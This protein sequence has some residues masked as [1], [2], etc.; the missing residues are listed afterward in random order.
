[1]ASIDSFEFLF[2]EVSHLFSCYR[3]GLA[4]IGTY[5]TLKKA[6]QISNYVVNGL[7]NNV[8]I[9][10]HSKRDLRVQFGMWAVVTGGSDGIGRA[11]AQELASRGMNIVLISRG[12]KRLYDA[13]SQIKK[14]FNVQTCTVAVDFSHTEGTYDKIRKALGDKEIGVLVNNVGMMYDFPR[15]FLDVP[16]E[17][18]SQIIQVNCTAAT[19][20]THMVLPGMLKRKR[21]AVVMMSSG[22][23]T[24]C[25]PQMT[26]YAATK[27]YLDYFTKTLQYEYKGKGVIIQC[28]KPFYVATKMTEYSETLSNPNLWI[29]S[30]SIY[31]RHAVKTLGRVPV[32]TGYWP[33]AILAWLT[34]LI[35]E[36]LWMW[37]ASGLNTAL[38]SQAKRRSKHRKTT[39]SDQSMDSPSDHSSFLS[40]STSF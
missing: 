33:H 26:V 11:Y 21:G 18:L 6:Y 3:D 27:S 35:P 13:A 24:Q 15:Y 1:M 23:C 32:S 34:E 17:N 30:A 22:A 28:L 12:Q 40:P 4:F 38:R 36:F 14:M 19:L 29:P 16:A 39:E 5:Y 10:L 20:M 31:A 2:R 8:L 37:A 7:A 25:T 9:Q